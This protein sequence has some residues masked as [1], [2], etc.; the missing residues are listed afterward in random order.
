MATHGR[1]RRPATGRPRRPAVVAV[2]DPLR[3][4]KPPSSKN[5]PG[6]LL[7]DLRRSTTASADGS[8]SSPTSASSPPPASALT[9]TPSSPARGPWTRPARPPTCGATPPF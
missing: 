4:K 2:T 1:I 8:A 5:S 3:A 9:S 7:A 6:K